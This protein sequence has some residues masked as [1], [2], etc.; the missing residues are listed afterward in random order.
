VLGKAKVISYKDL[1][2]AR[3][4]RVVKDAAREAKGKGKRSRKRKR[5][6]LKAKDIIINKV[7]RVRK[8]KSIILKAEVEELEEPKPELKTKITRTNKALVLLRALVIQTPIT[9]DKIILKL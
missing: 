8:R 9:K 4:K 3:A 6:T 2:K 5:V 7:K 1:K